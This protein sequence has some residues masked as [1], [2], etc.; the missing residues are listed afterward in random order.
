MHS[1]RTIA[2]AAVLVPALPW[3][4]FAQDPQ[5]QSKTP[6][7]MI[8]EQRKLEAADVDRQ[9]NMRMNR[10]KAM[11]GNEAAAND[12]WRAIRPVEPANKKPANRGADAARR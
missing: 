8:E 2:W 1:L 3:A 10:E 4:A 9:Y 11:R 5:Q 7:Q 6:M 12:P